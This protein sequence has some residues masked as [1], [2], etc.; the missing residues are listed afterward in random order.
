[1]ALLVNFG[2]KSVDVERIIYDKA[3]E[4][5]SHEF[6]LSSRKFAPVAVF[7]TGHLVYQ[8]LL[9]AKELEEEGIDVYVLNVHTIKPLDVEKIFEIAGKVKGIVT[10]EDHQI[11]GGLGSA[12]S[13]VLMNF[14]LR[15]QYNL[16]IIPPIK[17]LGLQN[18]FG[19]SGKPEELLKKYGMDKEAVKKAVKEFFFTII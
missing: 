14:D 6:A 9:A 19:E 12:I 17:F 11:Y 7:A 10:L 4:N 3:R 8:A 1:L 13:E 15:K 16:E 5:G 18:T 2:E